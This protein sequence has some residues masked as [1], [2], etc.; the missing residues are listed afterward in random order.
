MSLQNIINNA[1]QIVVGR[2]KV[3]SSTVSRSGRFLT[4]QLVNNQPF[5][6]LVSYQPMATYAN[7]RGVLEDIDRLDAVYTSEIEI[8]SSNPGLSWIT[9]YQGDLSSAQLGQITI[10]GTPS[11]GIMDISLASVTGASSTD[12]VLRKGDFVQPDS[13]YLYP[14]TV[15]Q[16]VLFGTG[17]T[18]SVPIHRPFITQSAYAPSG[19]GILVGT[20]VTWRVK[21]LSKPTY[22]LLPSRYVEFTGD[23]TL[24]EVIGD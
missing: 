5:N 9:E 20:G 19:K 6:F 12:Y 22:V 11:A 16:D 1:T 14:Y 10:S 3:A 24:V 23:F 17:G 4:G 18:V 2:T 13:G 15:T 8:G 21:M 7:V